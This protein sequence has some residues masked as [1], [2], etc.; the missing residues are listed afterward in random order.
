MSSSSSTSD[1]SVVPSMS[2]ADRACEFGR[3]GDEDSL[4]SLLETDPTVIN[5]QGNLG[6]CKAASP[7]VVLL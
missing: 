2:A 7:S 5:K 3:R 4:L 1:E 6:K